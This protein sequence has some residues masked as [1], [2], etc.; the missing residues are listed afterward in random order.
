MDNQ[1]KYETLAEVVAE[2]S[3]QEEAIK[4]AALAADMDTVNRL[5]MER[6]PL[7]VEKTRL[8]L[9]ENKDLVASETEALKDAIA[10]AVAN[11]KLGQNDVGEVIEKLSFFI[12]DGETYLLLNP[13]KLKRLPT[14]R[15]PK[16]NKNGG[17][18]DSDPVFRIVDGQR[19]ETTV[20]EAVQAYASDELKRTGAF[21][22]GSW[23][24]LLPKV[25]EDLGEAKFS[26]VA[27]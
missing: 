16:A 4:A 3:L 14:P 10:E 6:V 18:S 8:A 11:S 9:E 21:S 24:T 15:A 2:L 7:L 26:L 27:E 1:S 25:N 17:L 20:G 5:A 12:E 13:K 19:E 23:T 22:R